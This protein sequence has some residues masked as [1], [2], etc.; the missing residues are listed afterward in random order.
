MTTPFTIDLT[1]NLPDGGRLAKQLINIY[2]ADMPADIDKTAY[3][4]CEADKAIQAQKFV[5]LTL[6][7]ADVWSG[8]EGSLKVFA[9]FSV[10]GEASAFVEKVIAEY[11]NGFPDC[12][13]RASDGYFPNTGSR[14]DI[15]LQPTDWSAEVKQA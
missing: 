9:R 1:I 10:S 4:L 6:K 12:L 5:E 11:M 8:N 15:P 2:F 14:P 3:K 7:R 13:R